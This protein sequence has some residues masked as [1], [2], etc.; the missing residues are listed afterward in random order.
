MAFL[1]QGEGSYPAAE[2]YYRRSMELIPGEAQA[3]HWYSHFLSYHVNR[4]QEGLAMLRKALVLNPLGKELQSMHGHLLFLAGQLDESLDILTRATQRNPEFPMTYGLLSFEF[5]ATG[6]LAAALH[7]ARRGVQLPS[8]DSL[9]RSM[10]CASLVALAEASSANA[11]YASLQADVPMAKNDP[12]WL[13]F[14]NQTIPEVSKIVAGLGTDSHPMDWPS[15]AFVYF[16]AE[17][18]EKVIELLRAFLPEWFGAGDISVHPAVVLAAVWAGISLIETSEPGRGS[19]LMD[20]ALRTM[21]SMDR[22]IGY[23][24]GIGDVFV[25]ACRGEKEEAIHALKATFDS[26]WRK[27]WWQLRHPIFDSLREEPQ[28]NAIIA[29]LETDIANQTTLYELHQNDPV[30][31]ESWSLE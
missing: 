16:K 13:A 22:N 12:L 23:G 25:Y 7:W 24:Y 3:Y 29:D 20:Q 8:T 21:D 9:T 28:F 2:A 15:Y 14:E 17:Q 19:Y 11:C 18:Y 10:E 1:K 4:P 26:G 5:Q 6:K 30:W 27:D 31:A